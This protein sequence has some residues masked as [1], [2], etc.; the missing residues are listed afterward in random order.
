MGS[1][2]GFIAG[3]AVAC[4]R[5]GDFCPIDLCVRLGHATSI[6]QRGWR[7]HGPTLSS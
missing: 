1:Y 3:E 6:V 5:G 7:V 2:V 4:F